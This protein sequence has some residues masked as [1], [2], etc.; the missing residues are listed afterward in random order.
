MPT[1]SRH[2]AAAATPA[3]NFSAYCDL[4]TSLSGLLASEADAVM[5]RMRQSLQITHAQHCEAVAVAFGEGA[6][7]GGAQLGGAQP[8]GA[9]TANRPVARPAAPKARQGVHPPA[10]G[11]AASDPLLYQCVSVYWPEFDGWYE[12][13]VVDVN[14]AGEH[15]TLYTETQ[16]EFRC[17]LRTWTDGVKVLGP[18]SALLMAQVAAQGY[19][20]AATPAAA[21]A[22][23]AAGAAGAARAQLGALSWEQLEAK[24]HG[25]RSANTVLAIDDEV[26]LRKANIQA[27]L[28]ALGESDDE[29]E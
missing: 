24:L 16:E 3:S 7:S 8:G 4:L 13:V 6:Q 12:G 1:H 28:A 15:L 9:H 26:A 2:A 5:H 23:A 18:A 27:R 19:G 25:A 20:P 14:A 29:M 21:P 10:V 11:G 22:V 17:N